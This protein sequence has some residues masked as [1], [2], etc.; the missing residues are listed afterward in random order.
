MMDYNNNNYVTPISKRGLQLDP[1]K[2]LIKSLESFNG[3]SGTSEFDTF[4]LR[5]IFL[6]EHKQLASE[7][8]TFYIKRKDIEDYILKNKKFIIATHY[9]KN[10]NIK[11]CLLYLGGKEHVYVY[12]YKKNLDEKEDLFGVCLLFTNKTINVEKIMD[13]FIKMVIPEKIVKGHLNILIKTMSGFSLSP[14]KINCPEIDFEINYNEDFKEIHNTII[15]RLSIE[16][17]KGLVLLHGLAGTGK[18]TYIRYLINVLKKKVIYIPP[19]LANSISDPGLIDFF[20]KNS[21]SI[22]VIEDA[23]NILMKRVNNSAQAVSN[24]LNL[25]DGLLSDCANIQILATFNTDVLN[26]DEALLRKGRLIAKY[27]FTKLEE[28]RTLKLGKKLG[29]KIEGENTLSDIYNTTDKS[30]TKKVNKIGFK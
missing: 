5:Q 18:T 7:W 8:D 30:F 27:E 13:I 23:E 3:F 29:I 1:T 12:I 10:K 28:S 16:N 22:L 26:I 19:N 14:I 6:K 24:I 17:S 20:L 9:L 4:P 15:E 2:N 25:S 21:N 11:K